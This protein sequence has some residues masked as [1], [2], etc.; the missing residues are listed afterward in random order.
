VACSVFHQ[1]H[2]R[3]PWS[4]EISEPLERM[5]CLVAYVPN[6]HFTLS[7]RYNIRQDGV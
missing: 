1:R 7:Q 6:K 5:P 2:A 4:L 3:S